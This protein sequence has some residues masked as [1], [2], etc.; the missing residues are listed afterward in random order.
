MMMLS[1][2]GPAAAWPGPLPGLL[3][4]V[5][6]G[7]LLAGALAK[8][9]TPGEKLA[10]PVTSGPL[11]APYGPR[12]VGAGELAASVLICVLPGRLAAGLACVAWLALSLSAYLLRGRRCACFG[13]ARLAAVGKVHLGVNV[14]LA[15]LG[16]LAAVSPGVPV[17][18]WLRAG[19]VVAATAV[20]F[21]VVFALDRRRRDEENAVAPCAG[22]TGGVRLYVSQTCPAC[23]SVEGLLA[24]MEPA[25]RDGVQVIRVDERSPMPPEVAGKNLP[26]AVPLA[27]DGTPVCTPVVGLGPVKAAIDA[28]TIGSMTADAR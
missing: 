16:L 27:P 25:R 28:I 17:A 8:L 15:A 21:G 7:P 2:A 19:V 14:A 1:F 13:V 24:G 10:W 3:S 9:A 18:S 23:R 11:R 5:L 12:L 20:T 4:A 26:C 6:A 22:P